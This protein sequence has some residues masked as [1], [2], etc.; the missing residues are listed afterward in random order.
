MDVLFHLIALLFDCFIQSGLN[1]A[2]KAI[3]RNGVQIYA[4]LATR[5]NFL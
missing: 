3:I 1:H 5:Q 4:F 2:G